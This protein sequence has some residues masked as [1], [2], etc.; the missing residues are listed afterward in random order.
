VKCGA[1]SVIG[2]GRIEKRRTVQKHGWTLVM[3]TR[4]SIGRKEVMS[5]VSAENGGGMIA[6][7]ESGLDKQSLA[8]LR[9]MCFQPSLGLLSVDRSCSR[10]VQAPTPP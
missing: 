8:D 2:C 1:P 6:H 7:L 10:M 5:A 4:V 9:S 3:R